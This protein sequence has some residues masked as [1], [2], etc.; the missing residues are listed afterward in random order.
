VKKVLGILFGCLV[1]T[2][3]PVYAICPSADL[4]GDCVVNLEDLALLSNQW[5]TGDGVPE[6]MIF[7][8]GGTFQ[9]GDS[10]GEAWSDELPVH[11][12]TQ[13]SFYICRFEITN[14]QYCEFL[15]GALAQSSIALIDGIVYQAGSGENN[16][17]CNT[18]VYDSGNLITFNNGIFSV[19]PKRKG[20]RDMSKDPMQQVTWVGA[21]A[22]CNWRSQMEGR[23]C[24]YNLVSWTCDFNKNGYR[25]PT[26][27]EW[28]Y[29]ARGGLSENRF[30]WGNTISHTQ[31]NYRSDSKYSY[32]ISPTR[33]YHP[34]WNDEI[35]PYTSPVGS[36]PPD[37][38]G[39]CDMVGNVWEWCNDW[40]E[41][42]TIDPQTNPTGPISGSYRALRGGCWSTYAIHGRISYRIN[43]SPTYRDF[44]VG[45]RVVL[46][47]E[48]CKNQLDCRGY[49]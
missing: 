16:P 48:N 34:I 39:L 6:D 36:F 19:R 25:L 1:I 9:M 10:F 30:P 28:E 46:S 14:G 44:F 20:G 33:G 23:E 4:T 40:Y 29:A 18:S 3:L 32:D 17:Y 15:N 24:C 2:V 21:A 45:F 38:F 13:D 43:S 26:E 37:E 7:I 8:S 35:E 49:L 31:A 42:Y 12:V 27:A 47:W 41:K 5:L 11:T 22:Y